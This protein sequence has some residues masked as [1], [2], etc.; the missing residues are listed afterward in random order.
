MTSRLQ[1][2]QSTRRGT[3]G[4]GLI[5]VIVASA[6]FL[7]LLLGAAV[8][9]RIAVATVR[10]SNIRL[11]AA[12]LAEEGIEAVRSIRDRGWTTHI[13]PAMN[14]T[15]YYLTFD[16]SAWQLTTTSP[17]LVDGIFERRV[18]FSAVQRDGTDDI[19][20]SGGVVD[21]QSRAVSV[22]VIWQ[23]PRGSASTS[24]DTYFTNLWG[25]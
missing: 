22:Q 11:R 6:I 24:I 5:E 1:Q 15:I 23:N 16:A 10:E 9:G 20:A 18:L 3:P 25:D 8:A 7:V 21:Q 17:L 12:F 4:F 13:Q 14:D 2:Q 19:V